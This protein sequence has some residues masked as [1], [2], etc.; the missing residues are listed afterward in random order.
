MGGFHKWVTGEAYIYDLA[1]DSLRKKSSLI[2]KT[3]GAGRLQL[4]TLEDKL[5]EA[6]H[7][8]GRE[9]GGVA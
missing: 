3:Q 6:R 7:S 8:G 1:I 4:K 2:V 5:D 9:G